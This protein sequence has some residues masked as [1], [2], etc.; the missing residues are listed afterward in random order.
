M[1]PLFDL[2][3]RLNGFPMKEAQAEFNTIIALSD[4]EH[5]AFIE[6]KKQEIV[7]FH[8]KNNAY[9]KN[10][11]GNSDVKNWNDIPVMTKKD[12]QKPL[13]DRLSKGYSEK[14]V[15][16]NKTSG[17]V[18]TLSFLPKTNCVTV[19]LGRRLFIGL[20]G[21]KLTSTLLFR[22]VFTEFR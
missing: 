9:Y 13:K 12:F 20:D 2:T 6:T 15:Y 16:V 22:H 14:T 5:Q 4:A 18:A 19:L 1:F 7:D 11:V 17:S 21:I 8:L 10:F 3:L